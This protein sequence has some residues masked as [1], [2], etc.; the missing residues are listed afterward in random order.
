VSALPK[1]GDSLPRWATF[2]VG[3][4]VGTSE[5]CHDKAHR[6]WSGRVLTITKSHGWRFFADGARHRASAI[7]FRSSS[8]TGSSLDCPTLRRAQITSEVSIAS[9]RLAAVN[10]PVR[11]A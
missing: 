3:W 9:C 4:C 6:R 2:S 10:R 11:P 5:L 7:R 8:E 1:K